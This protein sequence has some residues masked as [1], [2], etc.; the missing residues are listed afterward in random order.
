TI[1]CGF[2]CCPDTTF[3]CN[4]D[5]SCTGPDGQ[6]LPPVPNPDDP[7]DPYPTTL[8][9]SSQGG[10]STTDVG[11][12]ESSS[13]QPIHFTGASSHPSEAQPSIMTTFRS[14]SPPESTIVSSKVNNMTSSYTHIEHS[15]GTLSSP[16]T[17][18]ESTTG[19][20][21]VPPNSLT[22]T[23][24]PGI[25]SKVGPVI[26][27]GTETVTV[28]EVT[29]PTTL[30][31]IGHT[32]TIKPPV[33]GDSTVPYPT[34]VVIGSGTATL[35]P[36]SEV[37][38]MVTLD[39]TF[40]LL[41]PASL[42]PTPRSR[43][44]ADGTSA[45]TS[46]NTFH[47]THAPTAPKSTA[48]TPPETTGP[49]TN[50]SSP[51]QPSLPPT[52]PGSSS[53]G[54]VIAIIG[55]E[56]LHLPPVSLDST[57]TTKARTITL[58][59]GGPPTITIVEPS[60][61][62]SSTGT[63]LTADFVTF[64]TW[65]PQA[66]ITPVE[67]SV[68]KPEPS[69]D[70]DSSV[71]PCDLW[72]F[73]ICIRFDDIN[74]LGWKLILPPGIYPPNLKLDQIIKLPESIVIHGELPPWPKFTIGQDHVPTFP[75][76]PE[77]TKCETKTASLCATTTPVVVS[78]IEGQLTTLT[79]GAPTST[80]AEMRG[81]LVGDSTHEATVTKTAECETATATDIVVTCSGRGTAACATKTKLPKTGCDITATTTTISCT[82]APTGVGLRQIVE[83]G[84]PACLPTANYIIWPRDGINTDQTTAI[85]SEIQRL[86]P[87]STKVQ[88]SGS[89]SVGVAFWR[90]PLDSDIAEEMKR[91]SNIV[92]VYPECS[93]DC[94]SPTNEATNWRYQRNYLDKEPPIVMTDFRKQMA[95]IS[96]NEGSLE[97]TFTE[98]YYFD[99]S[100][101]EDIPVYIVDSGAQLDH[102]QFTE[103]DNVAAKTEFMFVGNDFDGEQ[104]R[105]DAHTPASGFC[106]KK[107]DAHGTAML[108]LVAGKDIGIAKRVKPI[109]VRVPRK[110]PEGGGASPED[111]LAGL[112]MIDEAIPD[113]SDIARAIL[114]LS[115]GYT[116]EMFH[117]KRLQNS[118]VDGTIDMESERA[119]FGLY[120]KKM[121]RTLTSLVKKG[122][123]VVTGAGNKGV[124]NAWPAAFA[125]ERAPDDMD[126]SL[127]D[128]WL[129]IPELVVA[130]AAHPESG[131]RWWKTGSA[132][133]VGLP[134]IYAPGADVVVAEG[135]KSK[136][137]VSDDLPSQPDEDE[138]GGRVTGKGSYKGSTGTSDATAYIAGLGAY[139]L[140]LHQV[141]RLGHDAKGRAP[142]MSPAG[143][144]S[145]IIN[146]GWVRSPQSLN[147]ALGIWNGASVTKLKEEGFCRYI[148]KSP[149]MPKFRRQ[150]TEEVLTGQCVPGTSP[151]ASP[152][153]TSTQPTTATPSATPTTFVCT[154]ETA[155]K[156]AP[157]VVCSR[158][159]VNGCVDGKCVCVLPDLPAPTSFVCT[160]RT[161]DKCAPGVTCSA[162][163]TSGC[164]DGK[165]VCVLPDLPS[166]TTVVQTT[167]ST[168]TSKSPDPV[169]TTTET[170]K[171]P[172]A[173]GERKCHDAS[174]Y[175]GKA[176]MSADSLTRNGYP[177]EGGIRYE[178]EISWRSDC[179]S[180][181]KT[182]D[183]GDPL[184]EKP[185]VHTTPCEN[186]FV[187][188]WKSCTGNEGRGGYIDV[189]CLRYDFT[190]M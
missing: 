88:A 59:S 98:H 90:V 35:P 105:D 30:I 101:G 117:G 124:I 183:C 3:T 89:K 178:M 85:L 67:I 167:L 150:E 44:A 162:P 61:G 152:T 139:F 17:S 140:R 41:P 42:S 5:F 99:V 104:R 76:E 186:L 57:M 165:C 32:F 163:Q 66:L 102:H 78:T 84:P 129:H 13:G 94:E 116:F 169:P 121:H 126:K 92:A 120:R 161:A 27:I 189:G 115:W 143:L 23:G 138:A 156:C 127:K 10:A 80:C 91:I 83:G 131:E 154:E 122:F 47:T 79:T 130:G 49:A 50:P 34:F 45:P 171:T 70:E 40:T 77:P 24:L 153:S 107:C 51:S 100:A 62:P 112:F 185:K 31:T 134:H 103:V 58:V 21:A 86:L 54:S 82:P 136:W 4:A 9:P 6:I 132:P 60:E 108:S 173:L 38:T 176:S 39:S 33:G 29:S 72:F 160:E 149:N 170:P 20:M 151:T 95:Y 14:G 157:G 145:Y 68:N 114:S 97:K 15:S 123:L 43:S 179:V 144:K 12:P 52:N 93:S 69:E 168:V 182:I 128:D 37:T 119:Q 141:G 125:A 56:T 175:T 106:E 110:M 25:T 137:S 28:P 87:P 113:N 180:T 159:R 188:N 64:T 75:S 135:D 71:I 63:S 158:P 11:E 142:N 133:E 109:I 19:V 187:E 18:Y 155:G 7:D 166:K 46:P 111:Y 1:C 26:V 190:P 16:S 48:S 172:V 73:S 181:V 81:C 65:P 164:V 36:V 96:A 174:I 2:G 53:T 146:N 118:A 22:S 148:P 184:G 74:I 147:R 55:T 177:T 8:G